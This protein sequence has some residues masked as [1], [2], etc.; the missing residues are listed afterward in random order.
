M[1]NPARS[2]QGGVLSANKTACART[3]WSRGRSRGSH[4]QRL[5]LIRARSARDS[6][7]K[8]IWSGR[9]RLPYGWS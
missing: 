6:R 7:G 1:K 8:K 4:A 5:R 9:S 2:R 3:C